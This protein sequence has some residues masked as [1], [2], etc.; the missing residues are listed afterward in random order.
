MTKSRVAEEA[1]R[2][3]ERSEVRPGQTERG[4]GTR[5]GGY[6]LILMVVEVQVEQTQ[7]LLV[8]DLKV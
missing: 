7:L 4:T 8:N 5:G 6:M 2:G 3:A 1:A